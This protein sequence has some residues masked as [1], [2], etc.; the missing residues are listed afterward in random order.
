MSNEKLISVIM[1][2][3]NSSK[4][5]FL[6]AINSIKNQSYKN[7]EFIICDDGSTDDTLNFVKKTTINDKRIKVISNNQNCGLAFALNI[8]LKKA[9]GEYIARMDDDDI[10]LPSRFQVE[11]EFLAEHPKY[12]FVSS[13]YFINQNQKDGKI[14]KKKEIPQKE[15]FLWTS[16][17]LHPATMFR[18]SALLKVG[19][20]R[21][22][23]ETW[24]AEDYDLFMRMYA[25]GMHGYNIQIPLYVYHIGQSDLKKKSK[26]IYRIYESKIRFKNFQ[27][28]KLPLGKSILFSIKPLIVGLLPKKM[29]YLIRTKK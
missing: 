6:K 20:Y 5:K 29:I 26:Y 22:I 17:F 1:G 14:I 9:K 7:W 8:C 25:W 24:R 10:S 21:V 19:G 15:D 13:N 12:A 4:D 3:H 18:K 27:N 11:A 2:I 28:M 16:P 23:K